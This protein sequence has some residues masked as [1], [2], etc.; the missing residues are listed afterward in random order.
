MRACTAALRPG[1]MLL[2]LWL[3]PKTGERVRRLA[4]NNYRIC[5]GFTEKRTKLHRRERALATSARAVRAAERWRRLCGYIAR[6]RKSEWKQVSLMRRQKHSELRQ[7]QETDFMQRCCILP[8]TEMFSQ[9]LC[10][11]SCGPISTST[12]VQ[13]CTR[14]QFEAVPVGPQ[15]RPAGAA[16][17][18]TKL[19]SLIQ[20][21]CHWT[22]PPVFSR[23]ADMLR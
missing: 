8:K 1:E 12:V 2:L 15:R 22:A 17:H 7:D 16:H 14:R 18:A 13:K 9:Q 23:A 4:A 20:L 19:F 10:T 11:G 21:C 3:W 5:T 6:Q